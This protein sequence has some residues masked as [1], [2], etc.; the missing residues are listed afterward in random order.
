MAYKV[1]RYHPPWFFLDYLKQNTNY[2]YEFKSI[3]RTRYEISRIR[4]KIIYNVREKIVN[5]LGYCHNR[6]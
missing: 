5:R 4:E 6:F 3:N 1:P 2:W